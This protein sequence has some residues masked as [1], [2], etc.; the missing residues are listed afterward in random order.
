MKKDKSTSS[1][2]FLSALVKFNERG[3]DLLESTVK[4]TKTKRSMTLLYTIDGRFLY[5]DL[6]FKLRI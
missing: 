3:P 5:I 1:K 4:S 6:I 2:V